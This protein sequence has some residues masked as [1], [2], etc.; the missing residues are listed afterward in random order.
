MR[1]LKGKSLMN[2]IKFSVLIPVY[3]V[4]KYIRQC[5]DSVACQTYENFEVVIIDDGSTDDSG[6]ICDE[7]A[8]EDSRF[9]VIHKENGGL[10]CARR[11][12]IK[13][14]TGNYFMFLDSDDYWEKGL[15]ERVA[16]VIQQYCCDMVIFRLKNIYSDRTENTI[17]LFENESIFENEDKTELYKITL[18]SDNLN[19]LVTKVVHR[20]IVDTENEYSDMKDISYGEDLLQSVTLLLNAKRVVYIEDAMYCYR[21]GTGMTRS[22]TPKSKEN[23]IKVKTKIAHMYKE[24]GLNLSESIEKG[25]YN[26]LSD[27]DRYILYA[28][29][30]DPVELR[31]KLKYIFN[32]EFYKK[33]KKSAYKKTSMLNK[34]V[35]WLAEKDLFIAIKAL[36]FLLKYRNQIRG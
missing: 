20:D 21:R 9:R 30:A 24:K 7:Y 19:N 3:N 17:K 2:N 1:N 5:L 6:N 14:A 36:S 13:I 27:F 18:E 16:D 15:I 4:E 29:I 25:M 11:E 35:I 22:V 23:I 34:Y 26:F 8:K 12:A 33:A 31:D 10:L 28:Y 32:T